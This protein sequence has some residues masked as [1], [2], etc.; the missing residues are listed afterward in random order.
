V[1]FHDGSDSDRPKKF[2]AV[3]ARPGDGRRVVLDVVGGVDAFTAPLLQ[4]CV[5]TQLSRPDLR[6]LV[7]DMGGVEY[8]GV[9][10]I[11]VVGE[12]ARRSRERGVRFRLRS[13][14]RPQ[15]V[16]PLELSGVIDDIRASE[17]VEARERS[18]SRKAAERRQRIRGANGS[19]APQPLP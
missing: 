10:G 1:R 6:E 8:L 16:Q 7:L 13:H 15:V 11:S 12:A 5:R 18:A 9:A 17:A 19:V 2:L 4:A 14:G 3:N